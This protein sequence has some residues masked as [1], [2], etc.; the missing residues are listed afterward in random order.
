MIT[1]KGYLS[2]IVSR[3]NEG[4]GYVEADGMGTGRAFTSALPGFACLTYGQAAATLSSEATRFNW[5][6]G[7][8]GSCRRYFVNCATIRPA[9]ILAQ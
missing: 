2:F 1:Q 9:A 8:M 7:S 6:S 3:N 4:K 5:M